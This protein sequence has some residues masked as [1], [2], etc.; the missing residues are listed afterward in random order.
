MSRRTLILLVVAV[1]ELASANTVYH[2]RNR[3][4]SSEPIT[5]FYPIKNPIRSSEPMTILNPIRSSERI[6][7]LNPMRK[8][9][10][11]SGPITRSNPT[12]KTINSSEPITRLNQ[13]PMNYCDITCGIYKHTACQF[14]SST[15]FY[16]VVI[17]FN[18]I[19]N[20]SLINLLRCQQLF[21]YFEM[22]HNASVSDKIIFCGY[23]K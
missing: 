19:N 9:I 22:I 8:P 20:N 11:S 14:V 13:K 21:I 12:R 2:I 6:T 18:K 17:T 7:R 15:L 4:R 23:P 16:I 5:I 1:L 10:R 3:I